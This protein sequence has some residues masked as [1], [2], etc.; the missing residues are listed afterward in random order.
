MKGTKNIYQ[1]FKV[2]KDP[3]DIEHLIFSRYS[4]TID[5]LL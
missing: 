5:T 2:T 3:K 1:L 4:K